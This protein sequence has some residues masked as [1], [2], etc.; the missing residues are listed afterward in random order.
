MNLHTGSTAWESFQIALII[1]VICTV[2]TVVSGR[3]EPV[4]HARIEQSK[5]VK[6][7]DRLIPAALRFTAG[8]PWSCETI[9]NAVGSL[10][11]RELEQLARAYRLTAEQKA[12]AMRCLRKEVRT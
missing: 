7:H 12:E 6:V 9:R 2:C 5:V 11:R 4:K 10:T 1:W 3:F 8:L